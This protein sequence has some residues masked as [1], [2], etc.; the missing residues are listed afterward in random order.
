MVEGSSFAGL[1]MTISMVQQN[2]S[3][4][5]PSTFGSGIGPTSIIFLASSIRR[6]RLFGKTVTSFAVSLPSSTAFANRLVRL[7]GSWCDVLLSRKNPSTYLRLHQHLAFL[8]ALGY[9]SIAGRVRIVA[10][11]Q[12]GSAAEIEKAKD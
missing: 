11:D 6:V 10:F 1:G 5:K 9:R 2:T 3:K 7:Q 8:I 12:R 4:L